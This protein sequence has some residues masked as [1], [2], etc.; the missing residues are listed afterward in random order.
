MS[1]LSELRR[2]RESTA[3]VVTATRTFILNL[4]VPPPD[5]YTTALAEWAEQA[6]LAVEAVAEHMADS[7]HRDV[8][9]RV[10]GLDTISRRLLDALAGGDDRDRSLRNTTLLL[11]IALKDVADTLGQLVALT[12]SLQETHGDF[13]VDSAG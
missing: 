11:A 2:L 12:R 7:S 10:A 3:P 9:N 6:P 4:H 5:A 1:T 8:E 13:Q